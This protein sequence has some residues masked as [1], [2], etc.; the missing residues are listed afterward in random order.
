MLK[1]LQVVGIMN[2]GGAEVMLMNI[3]RNKPGDVHFDFLVNN[4]PDDL[5]REGVFDNEIRSSGCEIKHIGTQ[6]RIGPHKYIRRFKEICDE[7]RPDVVH[8]HLNG[9]CGIIS[10]AAHL[11]GCKRI[12]AHCHADIRFRGSLTSR[13]LNETELFFQKLLI[14][15]YA[16]D[17]WGCSIE[18]NKRLYWPWIQ[19]KSVVINNAIDL[20]A[21]QA[22]KPEDVTAVRRSYNLPDSTIILGNV[23]RIVPHKNIA[24]VIEVMHELRQRGKDVAFIIVGRDDSPEYTFSMRVRAQKLGI[25]EDRLLFLGEKEIIPAIMNTFDVFI[26]PALKEGFGLVAVEAQAACLP[27]VLYKGFPESVD[28]RTGLC[29]FMNSFDSSRWADVVLNAFHQKSVVDNNPDANN[30]IHR[31]IQSHGFD[32]RKNAQDVCVLYS[33]LSSV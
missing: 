8:I 16:T 28:M 10:L 18:A 13:I 7:L 31:A 1:V 12:I 21:Y 11:A 32:A 3:L 33:T 30:M 9:K 26:G 22:V 15:Y 23:G 14:A 29:F 4:P 27:C 20:E 25:P 24:F 19:K 6:L 5:Y 2:R 17:W